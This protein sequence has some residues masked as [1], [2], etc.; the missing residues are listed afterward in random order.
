MGDDKHSGGVP[1]PHVP[2]LSYIA[3]PVRK[4]WLTGPEYIRTYFLQ[5]NWQQAGLDLYPPE[6]RL[7]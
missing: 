5:W 6:R 7:I 2:T 3:T 4:A 1:V